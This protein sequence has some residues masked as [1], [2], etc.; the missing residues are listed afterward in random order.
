MVVYLTIQCN[1]GCVLPLI[2]RQ[3]H[4][5]CIYPSTL[6]LTLYEG[7]RSELQQIK[8]VPSFVCSPWCSQV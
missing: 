3:W 7:G 4:N 5:S 1:F 2:L 6:R 8:T